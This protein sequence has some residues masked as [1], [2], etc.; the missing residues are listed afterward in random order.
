MPPLKKAPDGGHVHT[1]VEAN[2]ARG[3]SCRW[4]ARDPLEN[5]VKEMPRM[6]PRKIRDS[7]PALSTLAKAE[8]RSS[9]ATYDLDTGVVQF[10]K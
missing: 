6:W 8:V 5:A 10:A 7:Q 1:L 3:G 4:K 2:H 9:K